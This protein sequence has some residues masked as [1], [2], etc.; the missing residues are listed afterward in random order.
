MS[1]GDLVLDR[2]SILRGPTATRA[3]EPSAQGLGPVA[4]QGEHR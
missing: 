4:D 1:S 2:L 3:V